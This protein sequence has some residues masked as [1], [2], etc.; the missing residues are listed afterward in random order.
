MV[1]N[2]IHSGKV[3]GTSASGLLI[4]L[5][6]TDIA[7]TCTGCTIADSCSRKQSG[8]E[9][10]IVIEAETPKGIDAH[11]LIGTIVKVAPSAGTTLHAAGLLFA[12][13]MIAM[14]AVAIAAAYVEWDESASAVAALSAAAL[15][16]IIV[17]AITKHKKRTG[18]KHR[19][20]WEIIETSDN[21]K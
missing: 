16:L 11:S 13:P 8:N 19:F 2:I 3:T 17:F 15:G 18:Q 20:R 7:H 4:E 9:T 21:T 6:D 1:S 14:L 12:L 10:T 5:L